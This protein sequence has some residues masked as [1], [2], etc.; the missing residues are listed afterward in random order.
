MTAPSL[1]SGYDET[2]HVQAGRPDCHITV[3]FDQQQQH[4]PRFIV[5]L[6]YRVAAAPADWV[7]ITR[8]DHNETSITGHDVY[9]EGL[10][11]DVHRET[12]PTVHLQV[13]HGPLPR[14]TGSVIRGCGQYLRQEATYFIDVYEEQRSPGSPPGWRP[15]GGRLAHTLISLNPLSDG[16]SQESPVEDA[17]SFEELD[18]ALA[19]ATGTTPEEIRR[20]AED[21][22]IAPPWEAD[23]VEE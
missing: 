9:Q 1:P 5:Q 19:E 14:N 11:V 3:G 2:R 4:I 8:M 17:L 6:H 10:H 21:L 12:S 22:E 7:E 18:E 13:R 23:I 20:G 15:D 16:M